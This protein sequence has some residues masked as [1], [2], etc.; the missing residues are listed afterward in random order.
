[1]GKRFASGRRG[2]TGSGAVLSRDGWGWFLLGSA[3][4]GYLTTVLGLAVIAFA[5]ALLGW[6]PSV[7]QSGSMMPDIRPGDVVLA[8]ALPEGEPP[9]LGRVVQFRNPAA[10]EPDGVARTRLHR[11]VEDNGD[12]TY[13]TKGDANADPDSV[14]M[15]ADQVIGQGRL[16]VPFIGL[17]SVWLGHGHFPALLLWLALTAGA[18]AAAAATVGTGTRTAAPE[19]TD[20]EPGTGTGTRRRRWRGRG[21]GA[22]GEPTPA[23]PAP[24]ESGE[25]AV[26]RRAILTLAGGAALGMVVVRP[27]ESAAAFSTRTSAVSSSWRVASA[28]ALSA[29][30]AAPFAL[31]AYSSIT[32]AEQFGL[33]TTV[34]GSVAV[35][36]GSTFSGFRQTDVS[37]TI[38]LGNLTARNVR[39]DALALYAAL[40]TRATTSTRV[41]TL[42]GTIRPGVYASTTGAF[43]VS[44]TVTLDARG[45][46]SAVFVFSAATIA[47]AA[48]S[49]IVLANGASAAN[50]YWR[51]TNTVNLGQ[52]AV[53]RG[54]FLANGNATVQKGGYVTGRVM[55]LNG[56]ITITRSDVVLPA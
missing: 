9:E 29:G 48:S 43:T 56:A 17:P 11:I 12:G 32:N 27:E 37:G 49:V 54:T 36:P 41:P 55:S 14:A 47:T 21:T 38:E 2:R 39:A 46:S 3:S 4:R 25:Q 19:G 23:A 1:M 5:P 42:T 7:V 30:R 35:S 24:A 53:G 13:I 15:S 52:S 40:G 20:A 50:V 18:I 28:P 31:L 44:G 16:L 51:A 33:G 22:P 26:A 10:A 34:Q 8:E 45:D 6:H